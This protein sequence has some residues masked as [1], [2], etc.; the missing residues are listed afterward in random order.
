MNFT[1]DEDDAIRSGASS[2]LPH[3]SQVLSRM[4]REMLLVLKTNDHLRG[5]EVSLNSIYSRICLL[6]NS[7][8]LEEK[9]DELCKELKFI[10]HYNDSYKRSICYYAVCSVNSLK[11]FFKVKFAYELILHAPA[12]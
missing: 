2:F 3:I 1:E 8:R 12:L 7:E 9:N 10:V 11:N 4:P 6:V 5:L